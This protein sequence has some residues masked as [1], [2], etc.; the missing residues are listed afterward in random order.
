M[1]KSNAVEFE[2]AKISICTIEKQRTPAAS[3]LPDR[4]GRETVKTK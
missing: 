2:P 3:E 1:D 4:S